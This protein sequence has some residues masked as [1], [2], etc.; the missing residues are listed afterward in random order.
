MPPLEQ[1]GVSALSDG[2]I[3]QELRHELGKVQI[4]VASHV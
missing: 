4:N 3:W 2:H 1:A